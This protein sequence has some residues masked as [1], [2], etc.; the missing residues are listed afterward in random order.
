MVEKPLIWVGTSLDDVRK[1]PAEARRIIGHQLH[2][3]QQGV[4]PHDWKSMASVLP[5][6]YELRVR[7]RVDN[8]VFYIAKFEEAV[9]V[10]HAFQKRGRRTRRSDLALARE[11]LV[12][13]QRLRGESLKGRRL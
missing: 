11:R 12:Q 8:R 3:I 2:R 10:L 13:V 1:F 4:S 7:T 9:Y 5:G 6:V